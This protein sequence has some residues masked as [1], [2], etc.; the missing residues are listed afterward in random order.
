MRPA[1]STAAFLRNPVGRYL[2]GRRFLMAFPSPRLQ[3]VVG[4]GLVARAD[5][6]ELAAVLRGQ[7]AGLPRHASL[8]DLRAL[9]SIDASGLATLADAISAIAPVDAQITRR[10]AVVR[11]PG[12]AGMAVAGFWQ[13]VEPGYPTRVFT[14]APAALRWLGHPARRVEPDLAAWTALAD[15]NGSQLLDRVRDAL[16]DAPTCALAD[17]AR[18][19][20]VSVRTLQRQ[21]R[22]GGTSFRRE[23]E[24]ARIRVAQQLLDDP[25]R[26]IKSV[27]ARVGM[28]Q[29]AFST[30]FRRMTGVAPT[31]W[32][33]QR[34]AQAP[35]SRRAP[36]VAAG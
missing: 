33:A 1:P 7:H 15:P 4:W 34:A 17:V 36:T 9:V 12:T 19:L 5:A 30:C 3:V 35:R 20:A 13:V 22:I 27:A 21:L 26:P 28:S 32:R 24:V 31:T 10:A 16:V 23:V 29:A 25:E 11:P 14:D 6:E 2:R 8:T 18:A